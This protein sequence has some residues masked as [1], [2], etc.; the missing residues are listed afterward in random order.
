[1][2]AE[3]VEARGKLTGGGGFAGIDVADND[4][5]DVHLLLT[6][7]Q[8]EVSMRSIKICDGVAMM[9]WDGTEMGE[10]EDAML[11]SPHDCGIGL[12]TVLCG[13]LVCRNDSLNLRKLML[14]MRPLISQRIGSVVNVLCS[15]KLVHGMQDKE[16]E[17]LDGARR[18]LL[19]EAVGANS[20]LSMHV[21]SQDSLV[22]IIERR[23]THAETKGMRKRSA[24]QGLKPRWR[25]SK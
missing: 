19:K 23:L 24:I 18:A 7:A 3:R 8:R 6:A 9:L 17:I 5:V 2:F 1:M 11:D 16:Q 25:L 22:K 20:S 14:V 15:E 10:G 13:F 12:L 4:H 21:T